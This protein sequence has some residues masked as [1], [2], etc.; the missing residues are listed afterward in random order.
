VFAKKQHSEAAPDHVSHPVSDDRTC[1]RRSHND[2]DFDPIGG[3]GQESSSY[4]DC[5]SGKGHAGAF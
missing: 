1:S 2:S 5:F 3:C 4:K